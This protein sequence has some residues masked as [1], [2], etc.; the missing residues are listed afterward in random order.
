MPLIEVGI[1]QC[2]RYGETI[3]KSPIA[4]REAYL[5]NVRHALINTTSPHRAGITY[6]HHLGDKVRTEQQAARQS[7]YANSRELCE[8]A[9]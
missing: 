3:E 8:A 9:E 4:R 6:L 1:V 7:D 5:C 2:S